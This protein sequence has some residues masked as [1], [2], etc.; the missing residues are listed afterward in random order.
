MVLLTFRVLVYRGPFKFNMPKKIRNRKTSRRAPKPSRANNGT[1]APARP[2]KNLPVANNPCFAIR[3]AIRRTLTVDSSIIDGSTANTIQLSFSPGATDYRFG[4]TSVYSTSL[5]NVA[6]FSNLFDQWRLK[7]VMVRFD[8][9]FGYQ[10]L[11]TTPVVTPN[12]IYAT[13][14]D[15]SGD[16]TIDDLLQ[17][18]QVQVHNFYNNGYTPFQ[19]SLSPKPLRDIAGSGVTTGYGPMPVAPWLRTSNMSIPHY[20][21][22]LALDWMGKVQTSDIQIVVTVFYNLEFT[23]PK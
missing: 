19:V 17:Y 16:A 2:V 22:K 8:I 10:G 11:G 1:N 3:R 4:G 9:A 7:N 13:D 12:L 23:N 6:E 14:Y 20:G 21:L 18:P 5:P 15:D